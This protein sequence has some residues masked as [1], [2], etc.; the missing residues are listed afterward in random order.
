MCVCL[1]LHLKTPRQSP[2]Y[3][4]Y[5]PHIIPPPPSS[6]A[7]F[8]PGRLFL[9]TRLIKWARYT[10]EPYFYQKAI[11]RRCPQ[12]SVS[13]RLRQW[14]HDKEFPP[15]INL[16]CA[17]PKCP[18]ATGALHS[19]CT[20]LLPAPVFISKPQKSFCFTLQNRY[21]CSLTCFLGMYVSFV[22]HYT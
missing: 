13:Q 6:T 18:G 3:S 2:T 4:P 20:D 9:S 15:A 22:G 21:K 11:Y 14:S 7:I 5:H 17:T 8:P 1:R 12:V 16:C 10:T 19:H